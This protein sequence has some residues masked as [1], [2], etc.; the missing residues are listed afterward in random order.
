V[1]KLATYIVREGALGQSDSV[2]WVVRLTIALEVLHD[3]GVCHGRISARAI[4]VLGPA[5]RAAGFFLDTGELL[6]DPAYYSPER[7]ERG[8][9]GAADDAWAVGVLLY[10]SLTGALPFA[11]DTSQEIRTNM[12]AFGAA[13]LGVFGIDDVRLQR[14]IDRLFAKD[15][16]KRLTSV[17]ELRA[18]LIEIDLEAASLRAL[19]LGKPQLDIFDN[20]AD[21]AGEKLTAVMDRGDWDKHIQAALRMKLAKGDG[22]ASAPGSAP[23]S[24]PGDSSKGRPSAPTP[25]SLSWDDLPESPGYGID[26]TS[27]RGGRDSGPGGDRDGPSGQLQ[28]TPSDSGAAEVVETSD[29]HSRTSLFGPTGRPKAVHYLFVVLMM[30]VGGVAALMVYRPNLI[31]SFGGS[32][33]GP[34]PSGSSSVALPA[35][36]SASARASATSSLAP[37]SS[38]A[39][40]PASASAPAVASSAA[41]Q[42]PYQGDVTACLLPMFHP[43]TFRSHR[44]K[45]DFVC[46][47]THPRRG[48]TAIRKAVIRAGRKTGARAAMREWD[49][50]GWY[51]M[52]VFAVARHECCPDPPPLVQLRGLEAC[53]F[54]AVLEQLGMAG[55]EASEEIVAKAIDEF[56]GAVICLLRNGAA[57]SFGQSG[58][59]PKAGAVAMFLKMVDRLNAGPAK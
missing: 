29:S 59:R 14:V 37:S 53:H 46:T 25:L 36:A 10:F 47:E 33:P 44:P 23:I 21:E 16:A 39:S 58:A 27:L 24:A 56:Q 34:V 30:A 31:S 49:Q 32:R 8:E 40:P 50:L 52:A 19:H 13:P 15:I 57:R 17:S 11:G 9:R 22:P 20:E 54:K 48:G 35:T 26:S 5:C 1:D 28:A 6:D 7:L 43:A 42:G 38:V 12:D 2:G 45:L 51:E 3:A 18:Q 41:K 4:Q 55:S